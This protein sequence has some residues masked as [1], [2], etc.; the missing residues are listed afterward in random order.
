MA[1]HLNSVVLPEQLT[2]VPLAEQDVSLEMLSQ[3]YSW[4]WIRTELGFA[5][6]V[7][8]TVKVVFIVAPYEVRLTLLREREEV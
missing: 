1:F 4:I 3:D 7:K 2:M 5:A 6:S 8:L